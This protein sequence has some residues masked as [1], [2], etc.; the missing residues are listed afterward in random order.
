MSPERLKGEPYS[1]NTDIWSLG[2]M[3]LECKIGRNPLSKN[4]ENQPI[5]DVLR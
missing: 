2:L 4:N 5:W 1:N 3:L